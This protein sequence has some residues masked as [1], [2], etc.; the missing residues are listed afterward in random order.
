VALEA[1]DGD[2]KVKRVAVSEWRTSVD[3]RET[4]GAEK[5]LVTLFRSS[6]GYC[7]VDTLPFGMEG[8]CGL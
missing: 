2:A 3:V 7:S 6:V 8:L 4:Y 1:R 5:P